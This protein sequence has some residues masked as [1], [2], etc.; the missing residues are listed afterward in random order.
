MTSIAWVLIAAREPAPNENNQC[1][2][3]DVVQIVLE[4]SVKDLDGERLVNV[5]GCSKT[6][7]LVFDEK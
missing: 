2:V 1:A 3:F 6:G 5:Q 4:S 7:R